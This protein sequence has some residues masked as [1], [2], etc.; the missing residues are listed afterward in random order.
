MPEGSSANNLDDIFLVLEKEE[1]D[2]GL[3]FSRGKNPNFGEK[4]IKLVL[5]NLLCA[6]N[7]INSANVVH[8]DLKPAN[9]LINKFCQ[10]KICDF[11][12]SRTLPKRT[13]NKRERNMSAHI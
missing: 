5:Y 6:V 7:L 3:F 8:R 2:L 12:L 11:G 13:K 1:N 10:V 4:H 9:I